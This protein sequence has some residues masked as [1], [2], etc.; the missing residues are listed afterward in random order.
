MYIVVIYHNRSSFL[1]QELQQI[2]AE[3][4]ETCWFWTSSR[5]PT[6]NISSN[7]LFLLSNFYSPVRFSYF[8]Y[9]TVLYFFLI[10]YIL[11]SCT[12]FTLS[13]FYSPVRISSILFFTEQIFFL[14]SSFYNPLLSYYYSAFTVLYS[15]LVIHLL[16]S[17]I[18]F[19]CSIFNSPVLF[20]CFHLSYFLLSFNHSLYLFMLSIFYSP[21]LFRF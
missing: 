17:S 7:T 3:K 6:E 11:Q 18:H 4:W 5:D 2:W 19:F 8:L 16:Q 21:L 9:F 10:F 1:F 12:L 14:I 20:S 15:L 13:T